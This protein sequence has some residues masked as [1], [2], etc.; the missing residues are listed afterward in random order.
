MARK[1][2]SKP[3]DSSANRG[4]EADFGKE[5]ADT[6]R[7][8]QHPYLRADSA[9]RVSAKP[10]PRSH[11]AGLLRS[12]SQLLATARR[13]SA[14]FKA[15]PF[16]RACRRQDNPTP[17]NDSDTALRGSECFKRRAKPQVVSEARDNMVALLGQL[18]YSTQIPVCLWFLAKAKSGRALNSKASTS[19]QQRRDRRGQTLFIDACEMGTLIYRVHHGQNRLTTIRHILN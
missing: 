10:K 6:F 11:L 3:A 19:T 5:N 18:F 12:E 14:I 16:R 13:D 15:K 9:T 8:V 7:K 4:F 2:S 1:A 17:F